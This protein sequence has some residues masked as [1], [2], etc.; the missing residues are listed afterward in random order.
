MRVIL[1][2]VLLISARPVLAQHKL[3]DIPPE[4]LSPTL[5]QGWQM[6]PP[7]L[8]PEQ[9]TEFALR[10]AGEPNGLYARSFEGGNRT[11]AGPRPST[12]GQGSR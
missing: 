6:Q 5:M 11:A 12:V 7:S 3:T 9:Q 8:T 10:W 1:V 2:S 4:L